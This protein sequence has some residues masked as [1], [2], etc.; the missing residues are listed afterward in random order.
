MILYLSWH[1][2]VLSVI[3]KKSRTIARLS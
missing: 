2:D 1:V 3:D